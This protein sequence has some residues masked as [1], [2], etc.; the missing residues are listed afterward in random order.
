MCI[1]PPTILLPEIIVDRGGVLVSQATR[2]N[3]SALA[4][5]LDMHQLSE[6]WRP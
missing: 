3:V 4:P 6:P 5:D 1:S 2:W